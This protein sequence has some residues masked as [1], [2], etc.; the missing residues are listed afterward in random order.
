MYAAGSGSIDTVTI[1]IMILVHDAVALVASTE[2]VPAPVWKPRS[3]SGVPVPAT[4]APIGE[5]P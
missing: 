4:G 2:Y 1:P 5:E 3:S